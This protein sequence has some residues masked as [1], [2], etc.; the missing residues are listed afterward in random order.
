VKENCCSYLTFTLGPTDVLR[1]RPTDYSTKAWAVTYMRDHTKSFA[2][3]REILSCLL[4]QATEE[5][6][7]L[8]GN[9]QLEVILKKLRVEES[10]D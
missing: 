4:A 7:R 6:A 2:Y 8:G 3:T 5:V 9:P 10:T 1:Q